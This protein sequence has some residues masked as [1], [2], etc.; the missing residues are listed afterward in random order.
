MYCFY[1]VRFFGP[2]KSGCFLPHTHT[3]R[4]D[5][6]Q[7]SV[8]D[9]PRQTADFHSHHSFPEYF[10]PRTAHFSRTIGDKLAMFTFGVVWMHRTVLGEGFLAL[11]ISSECRSVFGGM[12]HGTFLECVKGSMLVSIDF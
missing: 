3:S 9:S 7:P 12:I 4:F 6:N 2:F 10:H 1:L 8:D 5:R 11:S